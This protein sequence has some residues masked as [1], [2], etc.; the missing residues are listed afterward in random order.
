MLRKGQRILRLSSK[1]WEEYGYGW[2]RLRKDENRLKCVSVDSR[3]AISVTHHG[4]VGSWDVLTR[5]CLDHKTKSYD[6]ED[7]RSVQYPSQ[8]CHHRKEKRKET[9]SQHPEH[10]DCA[11]ANFFPSIHLQCPNARVRHGKHSDITQHIRDSEPER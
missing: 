5:E 10:K 3:E 8:S 7:E 1:S 6:T 4:V 2:L 11:Q 9:D